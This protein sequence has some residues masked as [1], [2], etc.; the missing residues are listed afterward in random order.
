MKKS[1]ELYN[2][3]LKSRWNNMSLRGPIALKLPL[4]FFIFAFALSA[5][6]Q[7]RNRLLIEVLPIEVHSPPLAQQANQPE[8]PCYSTP[9]PCGTAE[10]LPSALPEAMNTVRDALSLLGVR[11]YEYDLVLADEPPAQITCGT[12]VVGEP[13]S[14]SVQFDEFRLDLIG[15]ALADLMIQLGHGRKG[16]G[17]QGT[18]I[19]GVLLLPEGFVWTGAPF[20]V[21]NWWSWVGFDPNDLH[22]SSTS[23][24]IWSLPYEKVLAHELGHCFG[25]WHANDLAMD[26]NFDGVDTRFDLMGQWSEGTHLGVDYLRPSN[27]A[28]I[29]HHFRALPEAFSRP[30]QAGAGSLAPLHHY[31]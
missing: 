12:A 30:V 22:W 24:T 21:N 9:P 29:R 4:F 19:L 27:Y 26:W 18:A 5:F 20:G 1:M 10:P 14:C 7:E 15:S 8:H 17:N 23:C 25:L 16:F 6:A 31:H 28:R 2:V 3:R 13:F 11:S